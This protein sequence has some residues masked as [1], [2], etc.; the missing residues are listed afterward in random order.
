MKYRGRVAS[1]IV[2]LGYVMIFLIVHEVFH[3][4]KVHIIPFIGGTT[5]AIVLW[6]AGKKYDEA[7]YY[8]KELKKSRE[9]LHEVINNLPAAIWSNNFKNKFDIISKGYEKIYKIPTEDFYINPNTWKDV[10]HPDHR[11][12]VDMAEAEIFQGL[13]EKVEYKI[14]RG[15]GE[16]RWVQSTV[17]P[18]YGEDGELESINGVLIDITDRK[19]IEKELIEAEDKYRNLV[20]NAL[21]GVYIYRDGRLSYVN[22]YFERVSGYTSEEVLNM[23]IFDLLSPGDR[24]EIFKRSKELKEGKRDII[25]QIKAR[26][27]QGKILDLELSAT[28]IMYKESYAYI[29]TIKDITNQKMALE[30]VKERERILSAIFDNIQDGMCLLDK[31]LNIV[32]T[33]KM[34]NQLYNID[35]YTPGVK[36]YTTYSEGKTPC[37]G[38]PAVRAIETKEPHMQVKSFRR[39]DGSSGWIELHAYPLLDEEGEI[40][41]VVEQV[42]DITESKITHDK[43]SKMAYHDALTGL[44]NRYL[45][46]DYIERAMSRASR[47]GENLALMFIDLDRFKYINDTM[48]HNLGDKVLKEVSQ[49]LLGCIRRDDIVS[50]HGGDE[51]IILME[52]I[53]KQEVVRVA[54]GILS[55]VAMPIVIDGIEIYTTPSIGIAMY[56]EDTED[57]E[58]LIKYADTAMYLA[59]DSGKNNYKFYTANL[60]K[61]ILRQVE[62][63]NGLRRALEFNEFEL[64]YQPQFNMENGNLVRIEA[65]IRWNHPECGIIPPSEFIPL[66][67]ETGLII[68][69][70][71]WVLG[72]ALRQNKEWQDRYNVFVPVSVNISGRQIHHI[73]F[74]KVVRD[75]LEKTGLDPKYLEIEI[76]ESIMQDNKSVPL[77]LSQLRSIG[78]SVSIDDFGTGYSSLSILKNLPIDRIKID[79]SFVTEIEENGVSASLTKAIIDMGR[80][81]SLDVIA[82]G[83]EREAQAEFLL[84]NRCIIGQGFLYSKPVRAS[85][86]EK[87]F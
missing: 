65:L 63:E 70:G 71:N 77:I 74:I 78:I 9:E 29:G 52:N 85:E 51:F 23:D 32:K 21:I 18:I 87:C 20:E 58:T 83:I 54:N 66:A 82:E 24:E 1:L 67:E 2:L 46:N 39:R 13:R 86:V 56:P 48:G 61:V 25:L 31:D 64:Y 6:F 5:I 4:R 57:A 37:S 69:I 60:N 41:G 16:T 59:K 8:A 17:K 11:E 38:C 55:K 14:I 68:P 43:I 36:C 34:L 15:D 22:S 45:L 76:T 40:T 81:L 72:E 62:I 28:K 79:K 73:N 42:R 19:T 35:D 53:H 7:R 49:R 3:G 12:Y 10:I 50:R 44:P 84:K 26:N 47:K 80:S 75:S 30:S 33:N 27:K